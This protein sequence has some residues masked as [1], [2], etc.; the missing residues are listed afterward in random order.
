[1][2]AKSETAVRTIGAVGRIAATG[3]APTSARNQAARTTAPGQGAAPGTAAAS[4]RAAARMRAAAEAARRAAA[5]TARAVS[6]EVRES[7]RAWV[8]RNFFNARA[9]RIGG[10]SYARAGELDDAVPESGPRGARR[11][12]RRLWYAE[13]YDRALVDHMEPL[14][15]EEADFL[16]HNPLVA[17]QLALGVTD[18]RCLRCLRRGLTQEVNRLQARACRARYY[19]RDNARRRALAAERRRIARRTTLNPR[20][21][22]EALRAAFAARG[23]SPEAKVRLGGLL[24]DLECHVDNCLRF[25]PDGEILGRNGGVKAWLREHA[26]EL[27]DRY[28]TLMRYKALAKRLRQAA[29]IADPVPASAVFDGP[30]APPRAPSRL[31]APPPGRGDASGAECE[32]ASGA[33]RGDASGADCEDASGA[34]RKDIS[35]AA[36]GDVP[37][38]RAKKG[39]R[40][41]LDYYALESHLAAARRLVEG[42]GNTCAALFRAVDAA[43]E[44]EDACVGEGALKREVARAREAAQVGENVR[45][46]DEGGGTASD[47][48]GGTCEARARGCASHL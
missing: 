1:M 16:L 9:G 23:A 38:G 24:E 17:L 6:E 20:P 14:R 12:A 37:P 46:G 35:G 5:D 47:G 27:F 28:K 3:T 33:G 2:A 10:V 26:P 25:G 45:I 41:V 19:A 40:D 39:R 4:A 31:P 21:T 13:A 18:L 34:G 15:A 48:G 7:F 43:L 30:P 11:E 8:E 36:G 29:G 42:C 44:G 22:P 32:D